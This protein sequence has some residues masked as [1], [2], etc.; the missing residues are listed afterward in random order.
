[1]PALCFFD[2]ETRAGEAAPDLKLCGT[3]RYAES[4][5]AIILAYALD[6]GPVQ[7][8]EKNGAALSF[9][10]FPTELQEHFL[11]GGLFVA[12]NASFD[13]C[14]WNHALRDSPFLAPRRLRDAM[15]AAAASNLPLKLDDASKAIGGPGKQEDGKKLIARF[16]SA[17]AEPCLTFEER[18]AW[19]RF[20]Q[21]A[22][23]DVAVLRQVWRV[24]RPLPDEEWAVFAAN[25][26]INDRGIGV[27]LPF[28]T[29]AADLTRQE[30]LRTNVRL[31][32]LTAGAVASVFQHQALAAW[33]YDRL[34][35]AKAREIMETRLRAEQESEDDDGLEDNPELTIQRDTVVRLL[36][37]LRETASPDKALIEA[38]E[39][40]EFGAGAAPKKFAAILAQH[41]RGRLHGQL[42]FNGA[43][44]TGRFSGKGVQPQ[45]LTRS[46][47]GKDPGDDS[48]Y[49]EA[50]T[51][52]LINGGCSLDELGA[53]G[54]GEVPARK[55]SLL[56]RPAIVAAPGRTLI[57]CD[58]AQIEARVL[59]WLAA[60]RGAE[61]LLEAF[62]RS[63]ADPNE[64]DLYV[65]SAAAMLAKEAVLISKSERQVGK[66]A[67]LAC[68]YQGGAGALASMGVNYGLYVAPEVAQGIVDDWRAANP[69]APAFWGRH[70]REASYGLFGAASRACEE[71][72]TLQKAGRVAF[73]FLTRYLGGALLCR[74]PSGRL[75][76]YPWCK[77]RDYE[78]K[79]KK[80]KEVVEIRRGLTFRRAQGI[81]PLYG[82][83]FAENVTQAAAADLL[84][85][86][87]VR[88]DGEIDVVMHAH[89]EIVVE[90]DETDADA[91][92][93][94]LKDAMTYAR[95]WADGLPLAV[96]IT[97]RW[98]YSSS[99]LKGAA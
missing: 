96:D 71:P 99:K 35:D 67:T 88:L 34:P 74:L 85:E 69:W 82:G 22:G 47:L 40:R 91:V 79:D 78:V 95:P 59:P 61:E 53:F 27:D 25:E 98:Y 73:L 52:N 94:Y 83:R 29:A 21:Y 48:G 39:L 76:T 77:V 49:W 89:D 68:G 16:C 11:S 14:I 3:Y 20:V 56:V 42:V 97:E 43:G 13:R 57:K 30:I 70:S 81:S 26:A 86:A 64:P 55:L 4:A 5:D 1:M 45:N 66:V 62:R 54:A 50:P 8:V 84:R 10:D 90:V 80:T 46:V 24:M 2:F 6:D 32:E 7:V 60:S 36:G 51:I 18:D 41:V 87:L 93:A 23:L 31:T 37:Y 72:G 65:R 19:A 33:V 17:D 92:I 12:W 9:R 75:L 63:D 44:Q 58:Y 15:A 28:C 38:L